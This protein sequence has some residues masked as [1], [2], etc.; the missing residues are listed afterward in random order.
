MKKINILILILIAASFAI[1]GYAYNIIPE[2]KV[3]SHWNTAGIV[4]GYM[5]KFF[6]LFLMPIISVALFLLLVFIPK[7]DPLR[8]NVDKFRSYY[9]SFILVIILFFFYIFMLT[10]IA[11]LG[12]RFNMNY[13]IVPAFSIL[14]IYLGA[15]MKKMKRNWFIGIKTPWTI[16]SD[17][18]WDKTHLLG[19]KLFIAAGVI[20]FL[21]IFFQD[22]LW[23]FVL[24]PILAAAFIPVVYSYLIYRKIKR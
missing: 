2:G 5:P 19:G 17:E 10:I 22:Y 21:G 14:F 18:V 15:I 13:A 6:G 20:A 3:A 1:A 8:K 16:S 23:L 24:I 4:D 7:I 9:D 11:N 12:Y